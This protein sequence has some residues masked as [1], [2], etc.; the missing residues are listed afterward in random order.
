ME[1]LTQ[2]SD[3][4]GVAFT[5]DLY[6][7]CLPS[8]AEKILKLAE[9]LKDYEDAEENGLLLRLPCKVGDI[10]WEVNAERKRISKFVIESITIY[11]CNVIQFN[12]TLLEGI[13]KNIVGFSKAELGKT[14]F[15]TKEEAEDKLKEMEGRANG[16]F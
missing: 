3:R 11:P 15:L 2:T 12:W 8:E 5:F 13:Y 14:V 4:G 1:R 9:K 10:V 7:N 6:I 16:N